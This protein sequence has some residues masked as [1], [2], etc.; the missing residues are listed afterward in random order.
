MKIIAERSAT[1]NAMSKVIRSNTEVAITP[2]RI[3]R[4]RSSF[5]Q[6]FITSQAMCAN[7]KVQM[8]KVKVT[9]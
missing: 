9:A 5:V 7:V 6:S 1:C 3:A 4:L 8:S 2:P